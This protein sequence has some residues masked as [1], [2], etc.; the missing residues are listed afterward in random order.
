MTGY[1]QYKAVH[2]WM[3]IVR[4]K[5]S[6][7]TSADFFRTVEILL[8]RERGIATLWEKVPRDAMHDLLNSTDSYRE[9]LD[10]NGDYA[11]IWFV[12]WNNPPTRETA[13]EILLETAQNRRYAAE[14]GGVGNRSATPLEAREEVDLC[15]QR[16]LL[17][18]PDP[19]VLPEERELFL[20]LATRGGGQHGDT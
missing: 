20:K 5:Q 8:P 3:N 1:L 10:L 2:Y 17:F 13:R 9:R 15:V 14:R 4:N 19:Y 11:R 12:L 7:C 18:S 16:G 6:F